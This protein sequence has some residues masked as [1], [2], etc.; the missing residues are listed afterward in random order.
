MTSIA[1]G[2]WRCYVIVSRITHKHCETLLVLFLAA[3]AGPH[4]PRN[5]M[6][7]IV[8]SAKVH[9]VI[10]KYSC[11]LFLFHYTVTHIFELDCKNFTSEKYT[12]RNV[13]YA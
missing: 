2:Q 6:L 9:H 4:H 7:G 3:K 13:R 1:E 10:L 11:V 12:E 5:L 8:Y